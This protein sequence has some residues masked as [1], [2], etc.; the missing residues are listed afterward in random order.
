MLI[1]LLLSFI[2][3]VYWS[4]KWI[5]L[6][7]NFSILPFME[8]FYVYIPGFRQKTRIVIL[9]I[10]HEVW[11]YRQGQRTYYMC[12]CKHMHVRVAT[13]LMS[14]KMLMPNCHHECSILVWFFSTPNLIATYYATKV[15]YNIP[16]I[17]YTLL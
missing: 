6:Y 7:F 13:S 15:V 16:F 8:L 4:I 2:L 1:W 10:S 12:T 9:Y 14:L 5:I 3:C 11:I 17:I